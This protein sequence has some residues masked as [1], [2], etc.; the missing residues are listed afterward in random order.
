VLEFARLGSALVLVARGEPALRSVAEECEALGAPVLVAPTDV[1]DHEAVERLLSA[2]LERFGR[3]DVW[4]D[5]AAAVIAAPFGDEEPGEI[6]RLITTN[7]LGTIFTARAALGIFERQGSG[8]LINVSSLLGVVPNPLVATYVASK[9]AVRGLSLSLRQAVVGS[10]DVAV[11]VVLPGPVDTPLFEHAANRT[12]RRLRAIPPAYAPER[13][14]GAIVSC[15]RRPRRQV[16]VG[17]LSRTILVLDRLSPRA[18]EFV[19]AQFAARALMRP[20]PASPT[21]GALFTAP[22][23]GR[24]HGNWRRGAL[25]RRL[26]AKAGRARAERGSTPP[27]AALGRR[28]APAVADE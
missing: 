15:A 11:C 5:A 23:S 3:I 4:I 20:E 26:G 9:F 17:V 7:V 22:R 6:R 16:T 1:G 25:R 14:A 19:V 27:R 2:A 10:R 24:V 13:I 18:T 28:S 8:T 12:G 21:S